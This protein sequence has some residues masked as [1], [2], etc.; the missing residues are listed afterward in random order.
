MDTKSRSGYFYGILATLLGG[1]FV[2][3]VSEALKYLIDKYRGKPLDPGQRTLIWVVALFLVAGCVWWLFSFI[4][5]DKTIEKALNLLN[6]GFLLRY[7]SRVESSAG[8][9]M[10]QEIR[11]KLGVIDIFPNFI[12]CQEKLLVDM[13]AAREIKIFVLL[14]GR[15]LQSTS[16]LYECLEEKMKKPGVSVKILHASL[17]SPYFTNTKAQE[18]GSSYKRWEADLQYVTNLAGHFK[19]SYGSK[20]DNRE[21]KE[22]AFWRFF[23]FDEVAYVQ[24]YLY[25]K[26]NYNAPVIK[27][28][29]RSNSSKEMES[30][31]MTFLAYF[32]NKWGEGE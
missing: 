26:K 29:K 9:K 1:I 21:H 28:A 11:D 8:E 2:N 3:F 4:F 32:D 7:Q 31:Y 23:I 27:L 15:L 12:A 30:L 10:K 24:P 19:V 18:R 25:A 17:Q 14:G 22:P 16:P 13:E 6:P 5:T 20:F